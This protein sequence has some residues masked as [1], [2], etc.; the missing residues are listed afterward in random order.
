MKE[1]FYPSKSDHK[2]VYIYLGETKKEIN[3]FGIDW[4]LERIKDLKGNDLQ[5][6]DE[7]LKKSLNFF[8]II[9]P[10]I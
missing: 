3:L 5:Y 7:W 9:N 10:V 2:T 6:V 4:I 8:N 1:T